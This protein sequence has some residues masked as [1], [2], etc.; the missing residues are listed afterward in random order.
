MANDL[1]LIES[2][3]RFA[4][5]QPIIRT[6]RKTS[7]GLKGNLPIDKALV[8]AVIKLVLES[9][10]E[11]RIIKCPVWSSGHDLRSGNFW[12]LFESLLTLL[13]LLN[14]VQVHQHQMP[15][16]SILDVAVAPAV[17]MLRY[18]RPLRPVLSVEPYKKLVLSVRPRAVNKTRSQ[19][20]PPPF[21]ALSRIPTAHKTSHRFPIVRSMNHNKSRKKH[22]LRRRKGLPGRTFL[23]N[24]C[25][26]ARH[27]EFA[28]KFVIQRHRK[29]E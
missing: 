6:R 12:L 26:V 22:V 15:G 29:R 24:R 13:F 3:L 8:E 5:K 27:L 14:V 4:P 1:T 9:K 7:V 11:M 28:A 23:H 20:R 18:Q 10:P 17:E 16:P 21:P 2:S 19:H 25:H